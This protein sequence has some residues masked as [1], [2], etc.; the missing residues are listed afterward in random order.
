M[1]MLADPA[2]LGGRLEQEGTG[3]IEQQKR[4]HLAAHIVV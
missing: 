3:I 1:G 4:A 2:P